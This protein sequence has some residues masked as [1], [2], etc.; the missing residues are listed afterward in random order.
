MEVRVTGP[1]ETFITKHIE[2]GSYDSPTQMVVEGLRL[3]QEQQEL[4]LIKK[5]LLQNEIE[6]G[7]NDLAHGKSREL[8]IES[9]ITAC[10]S[11][12]RGK[13]G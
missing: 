11:K 4:R 8:N 9:L 2:A 3:L 10:E 13:C 12:H 1:Y 5:K 6:Q 7:L